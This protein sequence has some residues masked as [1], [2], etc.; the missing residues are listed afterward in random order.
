MKRHPVKTLLAPVQGL[1]RLLA[2][3]V[4]TLDPR[5]RVEA[6]EPGLSLAQIT[7]YRSLLDPLGQRRCLAVIGD[8][9]CA[10]ALSRWLVTSYPE[11][12]V[13]WFGDST[14]DHAGDP[15]Q[16]HRHAAATP[17]RVHRVLASYGRYD[18]LVD[19]GTATSGEQVGLFRT[20][21]DHLRPGGIYLAAPPH[22]ADGSPDE[23]RTSGEETLAGLLGRLS[24]PSAAAASGP[25]ADGQLVKT[26]AAVKFVDVG[27]VVTRRTLSLVKLRHTDVATM[28]PTRYGDAWGRFVRTVPSAHI[29]PSSVGTCNDDALREK[30][31]LAEFEVPKL[32]VYEY[33][34]AV[35]R[36]RGILQHDDFIL[37]DTFR[38][39]MSLRQRHRHLLDS[40]RY[41]VHGAQL[42]PVL[43][44]L[45]GEYFW[46]D[47]EH[48]H[49][50]H[51]LT[52]TISRLW[53][54]PEL[55]REHPELKLLM[56]GLVPYQESILGY[57]G[58]DLS[59]IEIFHEP[60]RVE[61]LFSAMP[62]FH[63]GRYA[64]PL[65][66]E[67]YQRIA[68]GVPQGTSGRDRVFLQRQPGMWRECV[69]AQPLEEF[70][71][72]QGF[73][74]VRPE[75]LTL[76]EQAALFRDAKVVA[77]YIGSQFCG[78]LFNSGPLDLIGFVNPSYTSNNEY[79]MATALGHRLHQFWGVEGPTTRTHDVKGR[80]LGGMHVDYTF[81]FE[82]DFAL[83]SEVVADL[84]SSTA[85]PNR[86]EAG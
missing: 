3:A 44:E 18:A 8:G 10:S 63:I 68:T 41:F 29:S 26:I 64:S 84:V 30:L 11:A 77:G 51:F 85:G 48:R 35:A 15:P 65:L 83:L 5:D 78:Q 14:D 45:T 74:L 20:L 37:P 47:H 59:D 13:D 9:S 75:T 17:A 58:I 69:N 53:A 23:V 4:G 43:K 36:P 67:I 56:H 22:P 1:A 25:D 16:L 7:C 6:A 76:P 81:D 66:T 71:A 57:F 72:V 12:R 24:N 34:Q 42:G 49:F 80:P 28:L 38:K 31:L 27:V 39:W 32:S 62:A 70:F 19:C 61:R 46:L 86:A 21:F 82:R 55:K 60:V 52:E 40:S 73:A 50:G 79:L 33:R 54:W 2:T